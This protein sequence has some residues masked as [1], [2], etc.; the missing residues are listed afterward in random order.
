VLAWRLQEL[1]NELLNLTFVLSS[2]VLLLG[3]FNIHVYMY[4]AIRKKWQRTW[5]RVVGLVINKSLF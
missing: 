2:S 3:D 5:Q 1:L 4:T